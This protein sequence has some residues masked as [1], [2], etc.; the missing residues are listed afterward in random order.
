[1][2]VWRVSAVVSTYNRSGCLRACIASLE[3]QTVRPHEVIICDDG[4][5]GEHVRVI[6]QIVRGSSLTVRHVRQE[7]RGFRL[8]ASRNNGVR[9]A[10]GDYVFFTDGD[11]VLFPDVL[12]LHLAASGR[13]RWVSG[14]TVRLTPEETQQLSE[15][16][17]R[18]GRLESVWPGHD[19]ERWRRLLKAARRFRR[20]ARLARVWP[21]ESV[22]RKLRLLG[23]QASMPREAFET[24]NGFDEA[25]EGWGE[26]DLDLGLRLQLAG[27]RA[28]TVLDRSRVLHLHHPRWQGPPPNRSYYER[29][30]RGEFRCRNGLV[31]DALPSQG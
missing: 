12:E 6:E 21:S 29:L 1:M 26:E 18:S 19:D 10:A 7:D 15:D 8:A 9:A 27:Y 23:F 20:R 11:L 30:R 25:F 3:E 24:V 16:L 2:P 13:R 31:K 14:A 4:S 22:F 5:D 17:I 28:C